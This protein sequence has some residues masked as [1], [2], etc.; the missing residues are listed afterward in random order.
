MT[1]TATCLFAYRLNYS[2][3]HILFLSQIDCVCCDN[4]W[5]MYLVTHPLF[6]KISQTNEC[7]QWL[8]IEPRAFSSCIHRNGF[9]W[10]GDLAQAQMKS[11]FHLCIGAVY[12][13]SWILEFQGSVPGKSTVPICNSSV[14]QSLHDSTV[15]NLNI[16]WG[17]NWML[18]LAKESFTG[19]S[20]CYLCSLYIKKKQ[21]M[22]T[23]ESL[24]SNHGWLSPC[25]V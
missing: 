14:P 2:S 5:W 12:R 20:L 16:R 11:L 15:H 8:L 4:S 25:L 24:I 13:F 9:F 10:G 17:M 7:P 6:L 18:L 23:M 3:Y 21:N 22:L 19:Y 1:Q